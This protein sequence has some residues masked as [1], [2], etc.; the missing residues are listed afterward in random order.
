[1][2]L[3]KIVYKRARFKFVRLGG[4]VEDRSLGQGPESIPIVVW[5]IVNRE[6]CPLTVKIPRVALLIRIRETGATR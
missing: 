2:T 6:L 1:M 3:L 5:A 4:V